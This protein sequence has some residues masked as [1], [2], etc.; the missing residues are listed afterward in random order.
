M[1]DEDSLGSSGYFPA[2]DK[3]GEGHELPRRG[4]SGSFC[5]QRELS[6]PLCPTK[7]KKSHKFSTLITP[8]RWTFVA[9]FLLLSSYIE[10]VVS[11]DLGSS[12]ESRHH[13][14][15]CNFNPKCLCSAGAS[16]YG[17]VLCDG[18]P[19]ANIPAEL[20]ESRVFQ[21]RLRNN[22][23]FNFPDAKLSGSG[24]WGLEVSHNPVSKIPSMAFYGLE[25]AL[26]QLDL[27]HNKLTQVPTSSVS[28]LRKLSLLNLADNQI[29]ELRQEDL[30]P[31]ALSLKTLNLA[32]N[33]LTSVPEGIFWDLQRLETLDL[34]RNNIIQIHSMAF[35]TGVPQLS[36]LNLADN[37]M[38]K[39]PFISIGHV[40]SLKVLNL[41]NN[42]IEK[43]EDPFFI[44]KLRLDSLHLAENNL[45][46]LS[47]K[48]FQN[49]EYI[50]FTS[51]SSNPLETIE[52]DAFVETQ[53]KFLDLSNC[54][55]RRLS[56]LSFKGLETSLEALDLSANRLTELPEDIFLD[57]DLIK[58]LRL[59]DNMLQLSPNITFNGFRYTIKDLNLLGEDMQYVSMEEIG[60]MRNLRT[61]G[62][63]AVKNYGSVTPSQFS[64]F[65]PSLEELNLV[66]SKLTSVTNNAF[67]FVPS[68]SSMDLSNNRISYIEDNAF[69]EVGNSLQ[70]LR[71]SNALH[72]TE[73][74]NEAFHT[75]TGLR[76]LDLSNN[77]IRSLALDT[78][79]KM[80]RLQ[81]L[82][83]Q[84][85]EISSF[86]RGTFHSQANP[87][88]TILDLSFNHI[89]K[90]EYDTFRFGKLQQ[91]LLNDN[92][93]KKL[94]SRSFVEMTRL[95]ILSMEGN[96]I[97]RLPDE[98]F[99][100]LHH[101]QRL[102]L[103]FN[104]LESLN[105]AAFD[106]IGTLSHL[107]IDASHNNLQALRV[108]RSNSY[109]T[110]SNI[111]CLDL[112]YNNIS[113]VE[114]TFFEPVQNDL[115]ILNLSHNIIREITPDDIGQLRRIRIMDLS[116][117]HITVI[118]D[119]TFGA[120]SKLTTLYLN[121]NRLNEIH[122]KLFRNQKRLQYVDLSWN[123]LETIPE[124]LFLRTS[125]EIFKVTHNRLSE[126]PVKALNPVQ[127]SLKYLDLSGNRI[128]T[129]SDSQLNQI[130][131]L[132]YLNLEGN[133]I[134][135]IDPEAF[136]CVPN[137]EQ[138]NLASNPLH[139]IHPDTLNGVRDHLQ[140]LNVANTSLT[141][142]PNLQ[143]P[144][145]KSLNV[146]FNQLTFIPPNTLANLSQVRELDLSGNE[147]TSPPST[148]WHSMDHLLSLHLSGNPIDRVMNDSFS[149]LRHLQHLDISGVR[150]KSFQSGSFGSMSNLRTLRLQ[151]NADT[152]KL[153][154][155]SLIQGNHAL[156]HLHL[157]LAQDLIKASAATPGS[158]LRH[159]LQEPLPARLREITLEGPEI[160][161]L[162]PA[163]FKHLRCRRLQINFRASQ[164]LNLDRDLFL[165]LGRVQNLSVNAVSL[166]DGQVANVSKHESGHRDLGNPVT[167][168][169]PNH[170]RAVFLEQLQIRGN[171]WPCNC[172]GIGWTEKWLKR[173]R[174]VFCN[175][176]EVLEST[177]HGQDPNRLC[178]S[179][180]RDMRLASCKESKNNV[181]EDI[182]QRLECDTF[183]GSGTKMTDISVL[184]TSLAFLTMAFRSQNQTG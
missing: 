172:D 181:L 68:I 162:H 158:V 57:F 56:P 135:T 41:S 55:I 116:H 60:I 47:V 62:L 52:P 174:G 12:L 159:Q 93:I 144:W 31:L 100:N 183:N 27:S 151:L 96:Q 72:F 25:R 67:K 107:T 17:S 108:N 153:N 22:H 99:Q 83:L 77:H 50:N 87:G 148:A 131:L 34:S 81:H 26:W 115:K 19:L 7:S 134:S 160:N 35:Q 94:D 184:A 16:E 40:K 119:P 46:N 123:K 5:H 101:L 147:L 20:Q 79:H 89:E 70:F 64:D 146:S 66:D 175:H 150:A 182:K 118:E 117:N 1:N 18:V 171:R 90:V 28:V 69:R 73:L 9:A 43:I 112:S 114:V 80:T 85:N 13:H 109:P 166:S 32:G 33:A 76:T 97:T 95:L 178:R 130:Q 143:L 168:Y 48:A 126:I 61:V 71:I 75:L 122:G 82:Y 140:G 167:T 24:L 180:L 14:S 177:S 111:M 163:A 29:S 38:G 39:I 88:L 4:G 157:Y 128:T 132:V 121:H 44:G 161:N 154:L 113:F 49:F 51:L 149:G 173:W 169:T 15:P 164:T 133:R 92:R 176:F 42:R 179:T 84:D 106:S 141:L 137:L 104:R 58:K 54:L 156:E 125:L 124:E 10:K 91:L 155:A 59:N 165:N 23:M 30:K 110:L 78:F 45:Q 170:P 3:E 74:P 11:L 145:L 21:L 36:E 63:S 37:L 152:E 98:T 2:S 8:S 136:C 102:E 120:A 65:S 6:D 103:A 127:S 138:L 142:L 129:I 105:F 53:I 139:R 86:K